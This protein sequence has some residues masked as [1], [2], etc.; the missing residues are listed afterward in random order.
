MKLMEIMTTEVKTALPAEDA[1]EAF[2][3]MRNQRFHHLIVTD[4]RRR[5]LGVLSEGD[6]GGPKASTF[7]RGKSVGELMSTQTVTATPQ[8]TVRQAANQLR[9]R[10]IGCL[11]ILDR[12]ELVGI[13]T[14]TD[15]LEL[16]GRQVQVSPA[17]ASRYRTKRARASKWKATRRI[18]R[19]QRP[20]MFPR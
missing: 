7:R 5:V 13:V 11:P 10:S 3:R 4:G 15:L 12:G 17:A 6:L 1:E 9:A 14:I 18:A 2:Q 8:T 16:L 20:P 19:P